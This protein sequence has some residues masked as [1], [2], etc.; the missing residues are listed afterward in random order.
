[1]RRAAS[2]GRALQG[3]AIVAFRMCLVITSPCRRDHRFKARTGGV[4]HC[5]RC[6]VSK[7]RWRCC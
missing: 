5:R 1:M 3:G 4:S 2:F 7:G 6:A